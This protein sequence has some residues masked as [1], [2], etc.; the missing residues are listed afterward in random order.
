[1]KN[2]NKLNIIKFVF[3]NE[4]RE[5]LGVVYEDILNSNFVDIFVFPDGVYRIHEDDLISIEESD[6]ETN[7]FEDEVRNDLKRAIIQGIFPCRGMKIEDILENF[8][9]LDI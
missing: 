4:S 9:K 7:E 8:Y 5:V 6:I 3:N 2:I 1:M